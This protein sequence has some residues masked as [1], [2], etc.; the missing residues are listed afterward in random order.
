MLPGEPQ[1]VVEESPELK[2]F[3]PP[4]PDLSSRAA[5]CAATRLDE[6]ATSVATQ[7][8][9]NAN[10]NETLPARKE[11][12]CPVIA[13]AAPS[14]QPSGRRTESRYSEYMQPTKTPVLGAE[15]EEEEEEELSTYSTFSKVS[16]KPPPPR[17]PPQTVPT[18]EEEE[19]RPLL[20]RRRCRS[21]SAL[22]ASSTPSSSSLACGSMAA[23]SAGLIL[24]AEESKAARRSPPE[25]DGDEEEV[26]SSE[27]RNEPSLTYEV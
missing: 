17:L 13:A 21:S 26:S 20:P 19:E 6:H 7:G 22:V 14:A 5:R 8:P 4:P 15:G 12:P 23:A 10:A 9:P 1:K 3:L 2:P 11:R 18:E 27:E 25:D 24:K 16:T